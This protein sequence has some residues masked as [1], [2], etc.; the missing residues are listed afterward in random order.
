MLQR[1]CQGMTRKLRYCKFSYVLYRLFLNDS[2]MKSL[3]CSHPEKRVRSYELSAKKWPI[4]RRGTI[5]SNPPGADG[6]ASDVI[7][8]VR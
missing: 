7:D 8:A 3:E 5:A 6:K 1:N 2:A 4:G